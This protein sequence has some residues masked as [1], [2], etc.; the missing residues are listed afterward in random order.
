M[1]LSPSQELHS[2]AL[3]RPDQG[4]FHNTF[5]IDSASRIFGPGENFQGK[6]TPAQG[7]NA[8]FTTNLQ[9]HN[10]FNT[11]NSFMNSMI[12]DQDR[13]DYPIISNQQQGIPA[14]INPSQFKPLRYEG[15]I[16]NSLE[17]QRA[18]TQP[19]KQINLKIIKKTHQ[20]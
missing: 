15:V 2:S 13:S 17:G 14:T 20:R 16:N 3:Q 4:L 12:Q 6:I 19:I 5:R 1:P 11:Q 9:I 8:R 10:E 18:G 7:L